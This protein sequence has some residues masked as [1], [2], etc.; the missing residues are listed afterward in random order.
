MSRHLACC[1]SGLQSP[2]RY[3]PLPNLMMKEKNLS[4]PRP[5]WIY[6]L[7]KQ[8]WPSASKKSKQRGIVCNCAAGAPLCSSKTPLSRCKKQFLMVLEHQSV[9]CSDRSVICLPSGYLYRCVMSSRIS[10]PTALVL[11]K[12]PTAL[13]LLEVCVNVPSRFFRQ[14]ILSLLT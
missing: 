9:Q 4:M 2:R 5:V 6:R 7:I 3:A 13:F 10:E 1:R 11:M 14:K 8:M 12:W